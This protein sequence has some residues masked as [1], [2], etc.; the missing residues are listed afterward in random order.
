MA[1][2]L[3]FDRKMVIEAGVP[4][5][6]EIECAVLGNDDPQA[7]VPGR[8]RPVARVLRL[9]SEVPG[10]RLEDADPGAAHRGPGGRDPSAGHRGVPCRRRCRHVA[11]GL[12]DGRRQRALYLNEVNTIP[13]FTTI[14]MYPKMWE[15]SG[16]PYRGPARPADHAG[17]RAA[18]REAAAEDERGLGPGIRLRRGTAGQAGLGIRDRCRCEAK[19]PADEED[20]ENVGRVMSSLRVPSS[21]PRCWPPCARSSP[22]CSPRAS[23]R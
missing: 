4:D 22:R 16:L 17:D 11:R 9:R 3:E 10:R 5:A 8:D 13:G 15:A 20:I 18:R 21:W 19:A 1:L 2:A 6:R 23:R 14:S 12:S 7:S